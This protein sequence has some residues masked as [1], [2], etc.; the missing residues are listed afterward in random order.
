[1]KPAEF[2]KLLERDKGG[3]LCCGEDVAVAPQHR[4]NRGMGG[5]S[6][7]SYLDRPSNLIVLCSRMNGLIESNAFWADEA[8]NYGWKVSKWE[9]PK[10]VPVFDAK[11][12][13]WYLLD[14][15]YRR[16]EA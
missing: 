14:D 12:G 7:D 15:D 3:C 1:M 13:C 4:A 10:E 8:R 11:D 5:A 2:K 9:T 16:Y 6:K